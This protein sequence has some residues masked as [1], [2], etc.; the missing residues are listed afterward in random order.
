LVQTQSTPPSANLDASATTGLSARTLDADCRGSRYNQANLGKKR[1]A[2]PRKKV[3]KVTGQLLE[4]AINLLPMLS[5]SCSQRWS[6]RQGTSE[7]DETI[8]QY[9]A[10]LSARSTSSAGN[11]EDWQTGNKNGPPLARRCF[12]C[13][14]GEDED[15]WVGLAL[16]AAY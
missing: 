3:K 7:H 9:P 10:G 16:L 4:D 13:G 2:S 1:P 14:P 6:K 11:A 5:N 8:D 15:K 12:K